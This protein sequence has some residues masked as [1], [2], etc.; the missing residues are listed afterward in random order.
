M[1]A[2]R[3]AGL[4]NAEIEAARAIVDASVP[5]LATMVMHCTA[6]RLVLGHAEREVVGA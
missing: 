5:A 6:M 4:E 3:E 1:T 2:L